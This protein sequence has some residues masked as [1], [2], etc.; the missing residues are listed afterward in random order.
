MNKLRNARFLVVPFAAF[1]FV[2]GVCGC[3]GVNTLENRNLLSSNGLDPNERVSCYRSYC[4]DKG[5]YTSDSGTSTRAECMPRV[6]ANNNDVDSVLQIPASGDPAR[7]G[8]YPDA[9]VCKTFSS[10][11]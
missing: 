8:K 10:G 1:F 4:N 5:E 6:D 2:V 9:A 3:A 7:F 11:G